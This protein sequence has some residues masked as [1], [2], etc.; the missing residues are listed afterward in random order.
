MLFENKTVDQVW[1]ETNS[2]NNQ[3]KSRHVTL[4]S[5]LTRL[6]DIKVARIENEQ[7]ETKIKNVKELIEKLK[8][9][10]NFT[11]VTPVEEYREDE[12]VAYASEEEFLADVKKYEVER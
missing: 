3:L 7:L 10:L 5:E 6:K 1:S 9:E 2:I 8:Q 4:C 12:P 11:G